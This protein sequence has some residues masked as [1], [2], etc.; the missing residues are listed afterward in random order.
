MHHCAA[1]PSLRKVPHVLVLHGQ[2]GASVELMKVVKWCKLLCYVSCMLLLISS[3]CLNDRNWSLQIGF[4]T[5]LRSQFHL[6]HI[7]L[8]PCCLYILEEFV[9]LCTQQIWYMLTGITKARGY[10]CKI[11]PGKTQRICIKKLYLRMI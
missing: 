3:S 1:C 6:E 11:F 2:D 4:F 9:L 7:I 5:N 10:G 8:R